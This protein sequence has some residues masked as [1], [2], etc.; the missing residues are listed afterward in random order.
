MENS[1]RAGAS[2]IDVTLEEQ[3]DRDRLCISVEDDGA[4]LDVSEEMATDPFYTTKNGKRT[5]LGLSLF[6]LRA[7]Q[8]GG[9]LELGRSA[10]GGLAVRAVMSLSHPDRT[11]LGDLAATV[12]GVVAANPQEVTLRL[13]VGSREV[14]V[15]TAEQGR[16]IAAARRMKERIGEGLRALGMTA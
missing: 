16:G 12:A 1:I 8:A 10:L 15:S 5:G 2:R 6:K 9:S 13:R 14:L 3:L 7:E 4:G 11:P